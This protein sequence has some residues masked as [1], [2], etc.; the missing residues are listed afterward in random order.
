MSRLA[1]NLSDC[2]GGEVILPGIPIDFSGVSP[3]GDSLWLRGQAENN[4]LEVVRMS[5]I[6][7]L[8]SQFFSYLCLLEQR[9]T[10]MLT[11]PRKSSAALIEKLF[12]SGEVQR[13]LHDG[14]GIR[15]WRF[16]SQAWCP[17]LML[18]V[19]GLILALP[20]GD[21]LKQPLSFWILWSSCSVSE[22]KWW[23]WWCCM[24]EEL[25]RIGF[26]EGMFI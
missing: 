5:G 11:C 19:N 1:Y 4:F 25:H 7:V 24:A 12:A 26:K 23:W 17:V 2:V 16:S 9:R 22:L 6:L 21:C 18:T 14:W 13:G 20:A 15:S 3:M 10:R 8:Q